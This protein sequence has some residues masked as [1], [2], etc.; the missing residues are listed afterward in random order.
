MSLSH[1]TFSSSRQPLTRQNLEGA[2]AAIYS[3][4]AFSVL[5][6]LALPPCYFFRVAEVNG[7]QK[8]SE[9]LKVTW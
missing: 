4:L 6:T 2:S 5:L 9:A 7:V 3:F 1:V 8:G